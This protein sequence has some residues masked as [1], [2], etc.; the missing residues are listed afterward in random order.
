[1]VS[2]KIEQNKEL[3][4]KLE[5]SLNELKENGE[6]EEAVKICERLVYEFDYFGYRFQLPI[7][8]NKAGLYEKTIE[9]V[10]LWMHDNE[11]NMLLDADSRP[12][13]CLG[14]AY[15]KQNL[16]EAAIRNYDVVVKTMTYMIQNYPN[17]S[18]IDQ[19]KLMIALAETR[20]GII[21]Y[22]QH[23]YSQAHNHF[24][25]AL[26]YSMYIDAI[27]YIAH[28]CC[29]G[30]GI[31]KDIDMAITGYEQIVDCEVSSNKKNYNDSDVCIMNANYELGMIYA[32]ENG[33]KNKEKSLNR[34]KKAKTL[35]YEVTDEYINTIVNNVDEEKRAQVEIKNNKTLVSTVP[36]KVLIALC[37]IVGI[38]SIP[39]DLPILCWICLAFLVILLI[40]KKIIN[41]VNNKRLR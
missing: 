1:M 32:I 36:L 19:C 41:V 29:F 26:S 9:F 3:V 10:N 37:V 23:N 20:I 14:D 28:M 15:K 22:I 2:E 31:D 16:Y 17:A 30:E 21:Y 6:Y 7:L 38:I 34:L 35:G 13:I 5:K 40:I 11:T 27:Y 25:A 33:F 4:E 12:V 18:D 39:L 8:Y 24:K